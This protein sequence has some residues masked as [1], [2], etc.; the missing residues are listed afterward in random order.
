MTIT[1]ALN[2]A[3]LCKYVIIKNVSI[4]PVSN[5]NATAKDKDGNSIAVYKSDTTFVAGDY[6]L[7]GVNS[8]HTTKQIE[9]I[10]YAPD[11]TI[12]EAAESNAITAGENA[13]VTISR[14]FN[15][16]AWNTLVL[17]FALSAEQLAEKFS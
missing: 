6:D 7:T 14:T 11:F 17:P 8:I 10:S 4:T 3:N 12:D 16:N 15:A 9:F 1:E 5:G 13:T 2:D